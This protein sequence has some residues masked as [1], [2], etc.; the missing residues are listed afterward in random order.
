MCD[1]IL[2][3]SSFQRMGVDLSASCRACCVLLLLHIPYVQPCA[4][5][6]CHKIELSLFVRC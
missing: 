5:V 6:K 2:R 1:V 4:L 3:F